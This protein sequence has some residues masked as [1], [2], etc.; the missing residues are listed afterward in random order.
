MYGKTSTKSHFW[1]CHGAGESACA[2]TADS[3]TKAKAIAPTLTALQCLSLFNIIPRMMSGR[4][5]G[6]RWG[7]AQ[8]AQGRDAVAR[9]ARQ[10][11]WPAGWKHPPSDVEVVCAARQFGDT[12]HCADPR[13]AVVSDSRWR[14]VSPAHEHSFSGRA[15]RVTSPISATK[16]AARTGPTLSMASKAALNALA[17]YDGD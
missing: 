7:F 9:P 14:G 11:A 5:H 1:D 3:P 15:M 2:G 17:L 10:A 4:S 12:L 8:V 13:R 16:I 6:S